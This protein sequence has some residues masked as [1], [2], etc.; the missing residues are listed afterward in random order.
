MRDAQ[1]HTRDSRATAASGSS[2][3]ASAA[4]VFL[5]TLALAAIFAPLM[6]G[7]VNAVRLDQR[8]QP[9]GRSADG[10][11]HLLGTDAV[12]SDVASRL[13]HGCRVAVAVGAA[14][15]GIAI[16]LGAMIGVLMG[17]FGGL[18]DLLGMRMIELIMAVPRLFLVLAIVVFLPSRDSSHLLVALIL[19]IGLTGWMRPARLMRAEVMRIREMEYVAAAR[20]TGVSTVSLLGRHVLPNAIGPVLVEAGFAV[21][22]AI[23]ME[24][25]LSFLGLGVR[26][27]QPS[28]GLMLSDA[29][30]RST[31][32]FYWWLAV[33]PG[34]L[35]LCTVGSCNAL[36]EHLRRRLAGR[37]NRTTQINA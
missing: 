5:V 9:P 22:S 35:I 6:A 2:R 17:Y 24:T 7:E 26:P 13:V 32:A 20:A 23:L 19:V 18:V 29:V 10:G 34:A 8:L 4:T 1:R 37:A 31:G 30:D 16:G 36:A 12:G 21:A 11:M 33:G 27:P 25:N 3:S 28:W 14:S 15:A